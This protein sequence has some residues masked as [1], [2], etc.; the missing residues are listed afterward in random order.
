MHD[1]PMCRTHWWYVAPVH[2]KSLLYSVW[3]CLANDWLIWYCV[4][5]PGYVFQRHCFFNTFADRLLTFEVPCDLS[6]SRRPIWMTSSGQKWYLSITSSHFV[7]YLCSC[8]AI[9]VPADGLAHLQAQ[10]WPGL[11]PV[12]IYTGQAL[13]GFWNIE[14]VEISD[15]IMYGV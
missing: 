15:C 9:T 7:E 13:K 14:F 11:G 1:W 4:R 12:Y 3:F 10:R 2:I 8:V 5:I 6:R